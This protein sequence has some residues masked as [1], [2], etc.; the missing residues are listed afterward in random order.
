MSLDA[1][2]HAAEAELFSTVGVTVDQS[3]LRLRGTGLRVRLLSYGTGPPLLLLHGVTESAAIWA[4]LLG[5]LAG[6]RLLAID[7]PGHG[8]SEPVEYQRG[9]VREHSRRV[10][11]DVLDALGLERAPVVGHSLGAMF[12]LWHLAGGSERISSLVAIGEPAV[13]L[14]GVRVRMPLSLLTVPGLGLSVLRSPSPRSV[15]RLLLAQGLGRAEVACAPDP[16]VEA[17]R[18]SVRRPSNAST[19]ASLMHAINRFRRPRIE[20]VLTEAELAAIAAPTTFIWGSDPPYLS[21]E[22]ARPSIGL[23]PT[24]LLHEVP[25]GHAPWLVD[26]VKSADLIGADRLRSASASVLRYGAGGAHRAGRDAADRQSR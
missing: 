7:L 22:R 26:P 5:Q 8:F 17:L 16:L 19:V 4:P 18:L 21:A 15:H 20:S 6:W 11:D 10:I 13:A 12:A 23:M 1:R 9:H 24:A 3:F 14:P 25:G 2:I